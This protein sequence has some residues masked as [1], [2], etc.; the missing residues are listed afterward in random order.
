MK[1][2]VIR[3]RWQQ[4]DPSGDRQR[5]CP[6]V[7]AARQ[8]STRLRSPPRSRRGPALPRLQFQM[9]CHHGITLSASRRHMA[10]APTAPSLPQSRAR[11][12]CFDVVRHVTCGC[13]AFARSPAR[14][15]PRPPAP[16]GRSRDVSAH[17]HHATWGAK[18]THMQ[19]TASEASSGIRQGRSLAPA[20]PAPC[21][22]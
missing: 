11:L 5:C 10:K 8:R 19:A 1:R 22:R 12:R 3:V 20:W 4:R 9:Q 21:L 7:R 2:Q 15:T 6:H 17:T 18:P 13:A 16:V 14:R